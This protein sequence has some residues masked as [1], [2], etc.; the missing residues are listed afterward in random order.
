MQKAQIFSLRGKSVWVAGH[1]GMVGSAVVERLGAEGCEILMAPRA[2]L[3]LRNQ[4]AVERW[5]LEHGPNVVIIAAANV[6]GILA[7]NT[8][9][10]DFLYDNLMI[11]ANIINSAWKPGG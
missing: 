4:N 8:Y 11:E 9:P 6:G 7:N 2:E 3:D 10:V 1:N 5:M